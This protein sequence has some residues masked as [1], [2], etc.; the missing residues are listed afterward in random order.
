MASPGHDATGIVQ[1][2]TPNREAEM[3]RILIAHRVREQLEGFL[4]IFSPRFS[5]PR[6]K[7]IGQMVFGMQAR[8][9]VKLSSIARA[10]DEDILAKKTEERLSRHLDAPG[11]AQAVNEF[12][13]VVQRQFI[14]VEAPDVHRGLGCF[15]VKESSVQAVEVV[16]GGLLAR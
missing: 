14:N 9:D 1:V 7:F 15:H 12:A 5:R 2:A 8:Q 10:L 6:L 4:G 11:L 13:F 16:H 3:N